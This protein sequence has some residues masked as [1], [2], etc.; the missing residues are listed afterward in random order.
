MHLQ[1]Q[2]RSFQ[3]NNRG[4]RS[5]ARFRSLNKID[6]I[7]VYL[8]NL[9]KKAINKT[10]KY[11]AQARLKPRFWNTFAADQNFYFILKSPRFWNMF[12]ISIPRFWNIFLADFPQKC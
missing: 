9:C 5:I 8:V 12:E 1:L 3:Q 7:L 11:V 2:L 6:L 10:F 4:I